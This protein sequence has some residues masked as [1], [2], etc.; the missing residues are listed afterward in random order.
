MTNK[1]PFILIVVTLLYVAMALGF[2]AGKAGVG[3]SLVSSGPDLR[4]IV[5]PRPEQFV[6]NTESKIFHY[7]ECQAVDLM[8]EKNKLYVT[9]THKEVL[10]MGY[11]SCEICHP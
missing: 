5:H 7:P 4:G 9:A 10:E 3:S 6:L 11:W 2:F 8:L 1:S